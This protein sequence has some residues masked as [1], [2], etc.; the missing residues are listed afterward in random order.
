LISQVAGKLTEAGYVTTTAADADEVW[1]LLAKEPY[2]ALIME[3]SESGAKEGCL[4]CRMLRRRWGIPII[5][6]GHSRDKQARINSYQAGAD[7]YLQIPFEMQE[8]IARLEG[9][10]RRKLSSDEA[11]NRACVPTSNLVASR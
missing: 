3:N 5:V 6:L 1:R 2:E 11:R 4:V 10:L 8:L 7:M 9:L